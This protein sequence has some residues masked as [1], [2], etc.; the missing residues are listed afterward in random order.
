MRFN[1]SAKRY[2]VRLGD[3]VA[4][5]VGCGDIV[6][7]GEP[8]IVGIGAAVPVG[9]ADGNGEGDGDCVAVVRELDVLLALAALFV[10]PLVEE[11]A[12]PKPLIVVMR[13]NPKIFFIKA[14]LL[15]FPEPYQ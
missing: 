1:G 14:F 9:D 15:V 10:P 13:A 5:V 11:H 6:D 4:V 12:K 2:G 8:V 7:L 3:I